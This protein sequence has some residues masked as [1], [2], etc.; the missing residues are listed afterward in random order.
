MNLILAIAK[1]WW[2]FLLISLLLPFIDTGDVFV[3]LTLL[4]ALIAIV[5]FAIST[6]ILIRSRKAAWAAGGAVGFLFGGAI[7]LFAVPAVFMFA[8]M[9]QQLDVN[10]PID[11]F[12]E[13]IVIPDDMAISDPIATDTPLPQTLA[14]TVE[15]LAGLAIPLMLLALIANESLAMPRICMPCSSE[16]T[17]ISPKPKTFKVDCGTW[18]SPGAR[19]TNFQRWR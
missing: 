11:T 18:P 8:G 1:Y 5:G 16:R 13:D 2:A 12:G 17:S 4:S 7:W 10:A 3:L 19:G 14:N 6:T 15:L 9:Q